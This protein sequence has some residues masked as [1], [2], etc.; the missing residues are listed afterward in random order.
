MHVRRKT[1]LDVLAEVVALNDKLRVECRQQ[2]RAT[3]ILM[4]L[5]YNTGQ[6]KK[7]ILTQQ[8]R[9]DELELDLLEYADTPELSDCHYK[10]VWWQ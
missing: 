9:A 2:A 5:A 6:L 1:A 7:L 4:D 10:G 8:A 3:D